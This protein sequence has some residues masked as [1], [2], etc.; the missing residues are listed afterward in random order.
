MNQLIQKAREKGIIQF[1]ANEKYITYTHQ[2]IKRNFQKPEEQV[3]A[4]TFCKLVLEYGYPEKHILQFVSVKMGS[5]TKEADIVVYKDEAFQK[6]FIVVECKRM[7]DISELEFQE[8][9][10][11][12][13]AYAHAL[14]G[15]TKYVWIT[16]GNKEEFYK[17]D[18]ETQKGEPEADIPYF[19]EEQVKKYKYAKRGFYYQKIKGKNEKIKVKDLETIEESDLIRIFKQSHDALWA[20]GE[21][22]P[23]QAF[24]ELDK[25]I[26]CKIWDEKNTKKG[27]PYQFQILKE[28]PEQLQNRINNLYNK[29]KEKDPEIFN[30]PIDLAPTRIK[31]IVKSFYDRFG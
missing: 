15:T 14:A 9:V 4:H 22:N 13:F 30:K 2:N 19:G 16:K 7:D 8:A 10:K 18:K 21:L 23:S 5:S 27:E 29:G 24:D 1:D 11:Q 6:P 20:G 25:L 17:F 31:T 3:Q 12:G 28:T 26:F